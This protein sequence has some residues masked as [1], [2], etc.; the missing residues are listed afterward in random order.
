MLAAYGCMPERRG[1]QRLVNRAP[2][3][4]DRVPP[5]ADSD[6]RQRFCRP[7]PCPPFAE[8]RSGGATR[9]ATG[10]P[11][12]RNRARRVPGRPPGLK[13]QAPGALSSQ[14]CDTFVLR[15]ARSLNKCHSGVRTAGSGGH[16]CGHPR[17]PGPA[18]RRSPAPAR[19]GPTAGTR[20]SAPRRTAAAWPRASRNRAL[21]AR[22]AAGR[23][24]G[25]SRSAVTVLDASAVLALVQD[26]PGADLVE[27]ELGGALLCTVNLA[28]VVGKLVDADIDPRQ[29]APLLRAAGVVVEP[30]TE[31]DAELAGA[32]CSVAGGRALSLGE[33]V[34]PVPGAARPL[35]LGPHRRS[36]LGGARSAADRAA[37]S[38]IGMTLDLLPVATPPLLHAV[39]TD[40]RQAA[41]GPRRRAGRRSMQPLPAA[42]RRRRGGPSPTCLA[43]PAPVSKDLVKHPRSGDLAQ[44]ITSNRLTEMRRRAGRWSGRR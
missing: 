35:E 11:R 36:R 37:D 34:L 13:W 16:P 9:Y 39:L 22:R 5:K 41:R 6:R 33:P 14:A 30:L 10:P 8:V 23:A 7:R 2:P 15:V 29:L 31:R 27:H 28:E 38:M 32:L 26:E 4:P 21:V 24:E 18:A 43:G 1:R 17:G 19:R 12:R 25:R 42:A 40:R 44:L 3:Q 20:A